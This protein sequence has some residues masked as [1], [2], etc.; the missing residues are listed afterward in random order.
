[1]QELCLADT[2][3]YVTLWN[4]HRDRCS[5]EEH[6]LQSALEVQ[7]RLSMLGLPLPE[8][9][10]ETLVAAARIQGRHVRQPAPPVRGVDE[11]VTAQAAE[12]LRS[13]RAN[14]SKAAAFDLLPE[15]EQVAVQRKRRSDSSVGP[16]DTV[17]QDPDSVELIADR[18]ETKML[19]GNTFYETA[20]GVHTDSSATSSSATATA[21]TATMAVTSLRRSSSRGKAGGLAGVGHRSLF[22]SKASTGGSGIGKQGQARGSRALR[23]RE[24]A[25]L[26]AAVEAHDAK[27]VLRDAA[28]GTLETTARFGDSV[29]FVLKSL[30]EDDDS[31]TGP[32]YGVLKEVLRVESGALAASAA[33]QA[34]ATDDNTIRSINL[35]TVR[36]QPVV[37]T[38]APAVGDSGIQGLEPGVLLELSFTCQGKL[39]R[40][41][42]RKEI[43][44]RECE[45]HEEAVV[46]LVMIEQE[47]GEGTGG[48]QGDEQSEQQQLSD[49]RLFSA[50]LDGQILSWDAYD[51]T[52]LFDLKEPLAEL[53]CMIWLST[54]NMLVS[55]TQEGHIRF[56]NVDSKQSLVSRKHSN[57]VSHIVEL[58]YT[59]TY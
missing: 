59:R 55:G 29:A 50:G 49:L 52:V 13:A 7:R 48:S 21:T 35:C 12:L 22:G 31:A 51:M 19:V 9:N 8:C 30:A 38:V 25:L 34:V 20:K 37:G 16:G 14:M 39:Q 17:E 26:D 24:Q 58:H 45:A 40:R 4:V 43:Q 57:T 10:A 15:S 47:L 56:W 27:R 3:G 42:I 6:Y 32:E 33:L 53:S 18:M 2:A 1:M 44:Y 54:V 23:R 46:G 5:K 11:R 41:V 28:A 36:P